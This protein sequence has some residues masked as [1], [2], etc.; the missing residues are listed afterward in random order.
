VPAGSLKRLNSRSVKRRVV[1]NVHLS[2]T[3][4][5]VL[6]SP[7]CLDAEYADVLAELM[8]DCAAHY[9][10]KAR[11]LLIRTDETATL[12]TYDKQRWRWSRPIKGAD[13]WGEY[14]WVFAVKASPIELLH[15]LYLRTQGYDMALARTRNGLGMC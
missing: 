5:G 14:R 7:E 12:L 15:Y 1:A 13:I 2:A 10:N 3:D 8:A 11:E 6:F 4:A 9:T